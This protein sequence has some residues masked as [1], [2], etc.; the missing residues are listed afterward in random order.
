LG[1]RAPLLRSIALLEPLYY[2]R[3]GAPAASFF[4]YATGAV[5]TGAPFV[6]PG[7]LEEGIVTT[8][9]TGKFVAL[10]HLL[11]ISKFRNATVGIAP[12]TRLD[13]TA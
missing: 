6:D 4:I 1:A 8:L 13:R 3:P 9:D 7:I 12:V 10:H 11:P 5:Y 2:T